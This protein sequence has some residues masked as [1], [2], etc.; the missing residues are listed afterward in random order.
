MTDDKSNMPAV[1]DHLKKYMQAQ[2]SSSSEADT[3]AS[4]GSA[5]IPRISIKGQ[6]FRFVIGDEE[7]KKSNSVDVVIVGV[8]PAGGRMMKAYYKKAFDPANPEPPDCQSTN[9]VHP[10]AWV[11]QPV[12]QACSTCPMNAFGTGKNAQGQATKGKACKDSKWLWCVKTDEIQEEKPTVYA[13]S[14][15]ATSL[16]SLS[17]FGRDIKKSQLPLHLH[18]VRISMDEEF[19]YA[20]LTFESIGFLDEGECE[21]STDLNQARPWVELIGDTSQ[22]QLTNQQPV[23]AQISHAPQPTADQM[24]KKQAAPESQPEPAGAAEHT[25]PGNIDQEVDTW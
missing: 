16:K 6:K 22:V 23:N 5:T 19:D 24:P 1:P 8:D 20:V 17:K 7:S 15:P 13:I 9:G 12:S 21:A 4:S 3:L 2:N 10:D 25:S 14:V 11:T 18:Q